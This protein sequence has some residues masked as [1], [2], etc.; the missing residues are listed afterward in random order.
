L[1]VSNTK[2]ILDKLLAATVLAGLLMLLFGEI[3]AFSALLMIASVA[4]VL[5]MVLLSAT[6]TSRWIA[7]KLQAQ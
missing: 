7:E 2:G 1:R 4:I 5:S 6:F 3:L